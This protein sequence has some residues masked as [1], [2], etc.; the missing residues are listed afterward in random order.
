MA[1][2]RVRQLRIVLSRGQR[3]EPFEFSLISIHFP[4]TN[5][6]W[7]PAQGHAESEKCAL[8]Q[9]Q[10]R[11]NV[12]K[13]FAVEC[14]YTCST[15]ISSHF[16]HSRLFA[17]PKWENNRR[18]G[19]NK[20]ISKVSFAKISSIVRSEKKL[21]RNLQTKKLRS[22]LNQFANV[23]WAVNTSAT[24]FSQLNSHRLGV[25]RAEVISFNYELSWDRHG[26]DWNSRADTCWR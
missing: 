9:P 2:K 7:R 6:F 24:S 25:I 10:R 19:I 1:G 22:M 12:S 3:R 23:L 4:L 21:K 11:Q 5:V 16:F 13:V 20:S 17:S 26:R 8:N 18:A 15:Q 14:F